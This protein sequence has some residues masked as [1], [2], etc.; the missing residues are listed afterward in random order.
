MIT[1]V[2]GGQYGGEG[3][4]KIA[5]FLSSKEEFTAVCRTGGV[6]SKHT[7]VQN[8]KQ[9][10][11]RQIPTAAAVRMPAKIIYGAGSLVHVPTLFEEMKLLNVPRSAILIDKQTGIIT[12][13]CIL[14]ERGDPLYKEL[15]STLTGVNYATARRALRKLT[16][17]KDVPELQGMTGDVAETLARYIQS[18]KNI[19][20]EGHQSMGLSNYHGDYPYTT[21]RDSTA[22]ELL[23]ELGVGP[24]VAL[25]IIVVIK[26][27]PTRNHNGRLPNEMTITEADALGIEEYGGGSWGIKNNRRRVAR[28]EHQDIRRAVLLNTATEL[29]LTGAD[30]LDHKLIRATSSSNLS[31]EVQ[32]FIR[33][34]ENA[35][36]VPVTLISTGPQTEAMIE[37][38]SLPDDITQRISTSPLLGKPVIK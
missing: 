7:V 23:S 24:R 34:I 38:E 25:R 28:I 36:E 33:D 32:S 30:Y 14:D 6:N 11:L 29:A 16:L 21:S 31:A 10:D 3:K 19:L 15:G 17:A 4:G 12:E 35:A 1:L 22:A 37:I 27:F 2:I 26:A 13:D 18:G 9:Y 5:A 8:G 20:V